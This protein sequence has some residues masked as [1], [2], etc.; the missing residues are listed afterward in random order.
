M[1]KNGIT[2]CNST[3]AVSTTPQPSDERW[4]YHTSSSGMSPD[5]ITI[6]LHGVDVSPQQQD[7]QKDVA[8]AQCRLPLPQHDENSEGEPSKNLESDEQK[9]VDR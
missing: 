8:I 3:K 1:A 9:S 6:V 4:R 2:N 7:R 5:Q